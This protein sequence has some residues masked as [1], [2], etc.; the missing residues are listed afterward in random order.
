MKFQALLGALSFIM[1]VVGCQSHSSPAAPATSDLGSFNPVDASGTSNGAVRSLW[2]YYNCAADLENGTVSVLPDRT[3]ELHVNVAKPLS[4]SAGVGIAM[5]PGSTPA[6]GK[7]IVNVTITHP[8]PGASKFTGFDVRGILLANGGVNAG[9]LRIPGA[10]DP[11][12]LNADGFTRWWNPTEFPEAGM[13]GYYPIIQKTPPAGSPNANI[14]PYK[15]F[16]DG[17]WATASIDFYKTM[18][19]TDANCRAVF[20]CSSSN[21]RQYSIQFPVDGT[22]VI[23]FDYAVDASWA[24]PSVNPP[25]NIPA[26]FPMNANAPEAFIVTPAVTECTL[27]GTPYGGVGSGQLVLS[28][29]IWDWQGWA[30]GD[31][32]QEIGAVRLLSPNI[33]FNPPQVT[34][35]DQ[36]KKTV[37]T[38]T[39]TGIPNTVG[40]VPVLIE[41]ASPG[42]SWKQGS[43]QAPAGQIAAYALVNVEVVPMTCAADDNVIC[44]DAVS[45]ELNGSFTSAVCMP[46]DPSDFY[47]FMVPSGKVMEGTITLDNFDYS[48]NDLMVYKGCPGDPVDS[49]LNPGS[50][51]EVLNLAG[52]ESGFYYISVLPGASAGTDVQPYKLS[53]DIHIPTGTCTT[54]NDN[55]YTLAIPIGLTGNLSGTVCAGNDTHDWVVVTVPADKVAGGSLYLENQSTGDIN[56]RVYDTYPG[57]PTYWGTNPDIQDEMVS[58]PALG[59]GDH[60]IDIYAQGGAPLG[61]RPYALNMALIAT[62]DSCTNNDGNDSYI[63]AD[64]IGIAQE[65]TGTVCFPSDPDWFAFIVPSEN[66]AA[67]TITLSSAQTADNDLY[68]YSD[69]ASDPIK[70]GA[71]EGVVDEVIDVGQL[72]AGTYYIKACAHPSTGLGDQQY[73]L[74]TALTLTA[75]GDRNFLIH[76]HIITQTDGSN[77]AATEAKVADDVAWA[78]EFYSTGGATHNAWGGSFT[79]SEISYINKSAWLAASSNEMN[80]CNSW[81]GDG[82]GPINVYY[83]DSFT[84]MDS[85]AAYSLM[86]CRYQYQRDRK[87]VV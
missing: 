23:F 49:A 52:L 79:L 29:H 7:F 50:A 5:Q 21:T 28:I 48:D 36:V 33:Q 4:K 19:L 74:T 18:N 41:I 67:G 69:P 11:Q 81:Y 83:V 84:D 20:R 16:G 26:D 76:A 12:L 39:A 42:T 61:D 22:P 85:A 30:A 73:T 70:Y 63:T 56:V 13:F 65:V 87:S 45:L 2:G 66:S 15:L 3:A 34:Q 43:Q 38:V 35:E 75:V 6:T 53:L 32:S 24:M 62:T 64:S 72:S 54:D 37:L 31:Y 77:P 55:D 25:V 51:D 17:L 1:M 68:L 60:Y 47:S 80:T 40:T 59:P 44:D 27:A 86:D 57:S 14:N 82:S 71:T 46:F 78:N 10:T 9:G 8:F 58:I